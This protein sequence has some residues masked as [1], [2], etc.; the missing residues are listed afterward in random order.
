MPAGNAAKSA[1][2]F[3]HHPIQP[4]RPQVELD[5]V[6][7]VLTHGVGG[8]E[9]RRRSNMKHCAKNVSPKLKQMCNN[10]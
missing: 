3:T 6:H 1:A 9:E 8:A 5:E 2:K 10:L 4:I 7:Q